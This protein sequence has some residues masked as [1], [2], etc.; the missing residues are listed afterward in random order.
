MWP[1]MRWMGSPFPRVMLRPAFPEIPG[2]EIFDGEKTMELMVQPPAW[3]DPDA[4]EVRVEPEMVYLQ[5]RTYNQVE[6][7]QPPLF[8]H[9]A[10][11]WSHR[12]HLPHPVIPSLTQ[13]RSQGR[14]VHL[15]LHKAP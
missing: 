7:D 6:R 5:A 11:S 14:T 4:V 8:H 3:C 2:Y 9:R 12:I 10:Q 15:L 1:P 13:R